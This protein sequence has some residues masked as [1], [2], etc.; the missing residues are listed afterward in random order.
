[1]EGKLLDPFVFEFTTWANELEVT[2]R[3]S[4]RCIFFIMNDRSVDEV[5]AVVGLN[6]RLMERFDLYSILSL[7]GLVVL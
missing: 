2:K 6:F 4:R 7:V 5:G 1:L 3:L